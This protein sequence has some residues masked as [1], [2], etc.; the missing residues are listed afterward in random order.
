MTKQRKVFVADDD[1]LFAAIRA[2]IITLPAKFALVDNAAEADVLARDLLPEGTQARW[3]A[4]YFKSAAGI[5]EA[6]L[7]GQTIEISINSPVQS[8]TEA[9]I[10]E[11]QA[12]LTALGIASL[13]DRADSIGSD[14]VMC[15]GFYEGSLV[16]VAHR[17]VTSDSANLYVSITDS[18][19]RVTLNAPLGHT[20]RPIEITEHS[21]AG[22]HVMRP[23]YQSVIARLLAD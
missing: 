8:T 2:A 21:A 11:C 18:T 4:A 9:R 6:A 10:D 3:A 7:A 15:A 16:S 5:D 12:V 23:V 17:T 14:S 22:I 19:R 13:A 1:A 20:A